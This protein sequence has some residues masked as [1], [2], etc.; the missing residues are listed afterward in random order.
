M[1][2]RHSEI[3]LRDQGVGAQSSVSMLGINYHWRSN[4]KIMLNVLHPEIKGDT[5]HSQSDGDAVTL[6]LQYRL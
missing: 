4:I 5:V 6:R 2:A 3:D 1:V